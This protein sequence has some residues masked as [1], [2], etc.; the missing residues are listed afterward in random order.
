MKDVRPGTLFA[1]IALPEGFHYRA[2]FITPEEERR[3]VHDIERLPFRSIELRGQVA[4][5]RT[6]HYGVTYAYGERRL[7]PGPP[8]PQFLLEVRARAAEWA[9]I[10]PDAFAEALVTEYSPG[11]PIGWH[12]DAPQF[13]DIIAGISLLAACRMKFRPYVSPRQWAARPANAPRRTTTHD[14]ELAARSAYLITGVARRSLEHSIPPVESLRYSVT[15]RTMRKPLKSA[16]ATG[17]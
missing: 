13:G 10:E 3:L 2:E 14:V 6:A 4:R 17:R 12:R 9:R 7:E 1:T 5:R 15:F 16:R 8:L 11:A